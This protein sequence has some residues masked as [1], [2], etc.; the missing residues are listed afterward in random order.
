MP[1]TP[2]AALYWLFSAAGSAKKLRLKSLTRSISASSIP[3]PT[4]VKKPMS[5]QARSISAASDRRAASSPLTE[6]EM[7]MIGTDMAGTSML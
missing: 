4:M 6:L 1:F 5:R 3:C 7:S 2:G